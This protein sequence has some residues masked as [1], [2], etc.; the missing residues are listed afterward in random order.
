MKAVVSF[1]IA[2]SAVAQAASLDHGYLAVGMDEGAAVVSFGEPR[3]RAYFED[4][5]IQSAPHT[6]SLLSS[7][8]AVKNRWRLVGVIRGKEIYDLVHEIQAFGGGWA[9]K[10][11]LLQV[12]AETF[13]PLFCRETQPAQWPVED[14]FFSFTGA[15]LLLVDRYVEQARIPGPYGHVLR[16]RARKWDIKDFRAYP[17]LFRR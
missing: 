10:T 2:L 14:T 9:V 12:G 11:I 1:L 7:A 4:E 16:Y 6:K 3:P 17:E 8:T 5:F 13:R 15:D